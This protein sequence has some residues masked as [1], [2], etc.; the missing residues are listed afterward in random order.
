MD[1]VDILLTNAHVLTMDDGLTQYSPGAVAVR[2]D[3]II[4]VGP[5]QEITA[6]Y[7]G[8]ES[9]DCGGK[10]LMPGLINAHTHV[11]MT[12][13][14]GLADD[15]RLDVWLMGYM[16]PVEREFV[17]PEFVRL[18]TAIACAELIR[19]GVTTFNDMYYFEEDVARAASEAG[20]R[21]VCGQTVMKFPTPDADAYEDSLAMS[22]DF[23]TRWKGH[24]LIAPAIAPHA[25]YTCT[26][27]ILRATSAIAQE[28]DVPL[29]THLAETSYEV[30]TM[31]EQQGMPVIPYVKKQT[32]LDAKLIAAHCVHIDTGEMRTLLHA[33]A[34]V[35]H[36]PSSNLKLASGFAP[37][38]KMLETGLNVGI[39]TDGAASNNDLDMFEEVRLAAFVAKAVTNDPTSL[40]A[41]TALSMATRIGAR[42]LH[43]GAIT[44]ALV[45]GLRADM[46]LVDLSPLHNSPA[47][48]RAADNVY[49]QIVYAGK[50]VDVTDVMCNGTWLMRDR[51][52]LTLQED[53]LLA[54][55]DAVA[56]R[57]DTF[58]IAREGSI[59]SKLIALGG[60]MEQES[61][62]VQLKVRIQDASALIEA[63]QQSSIEIVRYRHYGQHDTYFSFDDPGQGRLRY[64][65]D[66]FL[67]SNGAVSSTRRRLTLLGRKRED[68]F[69]HDVLLSRSRFLAPATQSLRFYREYFR[70]RS[71]AVITKDR[72][73]WLIN[74]RDTEFFINLDEMQEPALGRFLEIK[75]RTWSRRDAES[76]A[77]L[78]SELLD[79][80]GL[81]GTQTVASDYIDVADPDE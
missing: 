77:A 10:V 67:D 71:E 28:F 21:A 63:L 15:L 20:M 60:S 5:Q 14:R 56:R 42:A 72:Q 73:R 19:S 64:R 11:P 30:E 47:F 52:L 37:V 53:V 26:E 55:A 45:P 31:R 46:I 43:L 61:F 34:G 23:I 22:R 18:G 2:G 36:N 4:A 29:H 65:E 68:R 79:V 16:M 9:I 3:A 27:E 81:S 12:L 49:A 35:S 24:P 38:I 48:R 62:E 6:K 51:R 78:S 70:P 1:S 44:G 32:V 13:L 80:L 33:G 25:P 17:S 75:S 59:L 40:P 8:L 76:K 66:D 39:G 50:S 41:A 7:S 69:A 74:F 57:I 54:E 58:L